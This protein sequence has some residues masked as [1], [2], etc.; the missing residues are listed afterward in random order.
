MEAFRNGRSAQ[1]R[2]AAVFD[3][4]TKI[5]RVGWTRAASWHSTK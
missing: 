1:A 5:Y 2:A 3:K 4:V